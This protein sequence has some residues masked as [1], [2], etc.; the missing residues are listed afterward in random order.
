MAGTPGS[1][2]CLQTQ[3][4]STFL[5]TSHHMPHSS[6]PQGFPV[7]AEEQGHQG[8]CSPAGAPTKP[9]PL[10]SRLKW[11][12][13][14]RPCLTFTHRL[15]PY[16]VVQAKE[17]AETRLPLAGDFRQH[18]LKVGAPDAPQS[19][20]FFFFKERH[21]DTYD[22][23]FGYIWSLRSLFSSTNGSLEVVWRL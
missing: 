16:A 20:L 14:E 11:A 23:S 3:A 18:N 6:S 7:P 1:S 22:V 19:Q 13:S 8:T 4:N 21:T 5:H 10:G 17:A 9:G 12:G 15:A 2:R